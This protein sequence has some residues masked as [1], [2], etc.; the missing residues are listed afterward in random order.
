MVSPLMTKLGKRLSVLNIDSVNGHHAGNYTCVASNLAS[1]VN[2][3]ALLIVNGILSFFFLSSNCRQFIT[4]IYFFMVF[5]K[6]N[7]TIKSE[8]FAT[9]HSPAY[10]CSVHVRREACTHR[11]IS[12]NTVYHIGRRLAT[13]GNL[14]L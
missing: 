14:D 4:E 12:F 11:S 7:I 8:S 3:T 2:H 9:T 1:A 6:S 5:I 13:Y 10:H